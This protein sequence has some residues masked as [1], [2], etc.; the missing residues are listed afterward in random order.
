[1]KDFYSLEEVDFIVSKYIEHKLAKSCKIHKGKCDCEDKNVSAKDTVDDI[2]DPDN[3]VNIDK[4]KLPVSDQKV[5]RKGKGPLSAV[6]QGVT[7]YNKGKKYGQKLRAWL[8]NRN[9]QKQKVGKE[10]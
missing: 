5:L 8:D 10:K 2:L 9:K 4:D 6:K 1:M 3:A 7:G